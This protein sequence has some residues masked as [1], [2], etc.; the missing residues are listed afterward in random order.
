MQILDGKLVAQLRQEALKADVSK[1]EAD[2]GYIPGLAVILVGDDPAS[3]VYVRNKIKACE[4]V[5]IHSFETRLPANVT[6]EKLSKTI[7]HFNHDQKVDGILLQLPLPKG[8]NSDL[9]IE[10]I[11]PN[12][13]ADALTIMNQGRLWAG[14]PLTLPCTPSGVMAILEHYEYKLAGLNAVVIGRSAIVGRPMAHLLSQA[15]CTVT[16]CHSKTK[17]LLEHTRGADLVVVAAGK[18]EFIGADAFKKGAI[19]IDV[20]MHRTTSS[21]GK[22]LLCGDVNPRGLTQVGAL[23]PVP[24]GVGPMTITMLLENTMRLAKAQR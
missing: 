7:E 23:T 20:G 9:A 13:D 5:G 21:D 1:F 12:K 18:P 14:H 11:D 24:G 8:L 3:D 16:L 6:Q 4:R 2:T 15:N 19:V 10:K 22:T 17:N